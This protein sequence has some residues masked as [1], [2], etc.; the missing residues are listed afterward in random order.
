M[1]VDKTNTFVLWKDFLSCTTSTAVKSFLTYLLQSQGNLNCV[2]QTR[3]IIRWV[4]GP[5]SLGPVSFVQ[6]LVWKLR[7]WRTIWLTVNCTDYPWGRSLQAGQ[8]VASRQMG[9]V[10]TKVVFLWHTWKGVWIH[11]V[12]HAYQLPVILYLN[13]RGFRKEKFLC[14][15]LWRYLKVLYKSLQVSPQSSFQKKSWKRNNR[16][17]LLGC[18]K[19]ILFALCLGLRTD[20]KNEK[21]FLNMS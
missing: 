8:N 17:S 1:S 4:T 16:P 3:H 9:R 13:L 18:Y 6:A 5:N 11:Y 12:T 20:R 19:C 10:Y 14:A 21:Y 7:T 2:S 15:R